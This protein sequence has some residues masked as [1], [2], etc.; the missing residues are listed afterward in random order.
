MVDLQPLS[1]EVWERK[2]QLKDREGSL[3]DKNIEDNFRRVAKTL[4]A[5]EED[6]TYWES[7]FYWALQNGAVP[8]GRIL[9]NAGAEKYKP[10]TSLIN[11]TVSQIVEDSIEG[12]MSACGNAAITLSGGS[13][14]GYEF[15][16]LRPKGAFVKGAGSYTS[17][18][19]PFM[20]IFD[21]MCFTISSAGG[22]RGAQ[23]GSF[24]IWHPDVEAF[25]TAKR[26]D[27]RL[28]QFNLSLLI[29]NQFMDAVKEDKKY[30]LVFPVMTGEVANKLE[31]EWKK[32][33]WDEEYCNEMGYTVK[34]GK[35]LCKVYK[36]IDARELWDTIMK[37]TY[38]FAEP[39]QYLG[40]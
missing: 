28:R 36:T 8:A 5:F 9:S 25:I 3:V 2:Y 37:S 11:C 24:A 39:K 17:G 33:F 27:G 15:S 7:E 29:D 18:P 31:T 16:T 14:I 19:L 38:D 26:E 32:L 10:G 34:D 12:I 4:A 40:L 23:L 35:I 22:R 1:K 20:D 6:P 30:N 13:G 21:S